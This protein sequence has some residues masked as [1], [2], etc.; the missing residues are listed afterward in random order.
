MTTALPLIEFCKG[1]C[2]K[3]AGMLAGLLTLEPSVKPSRTP[4]DEYGIEEY[5]NRSSD[6]HVLGAAL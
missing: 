6:A 2:A 3:I 4:P 5:V 1:N